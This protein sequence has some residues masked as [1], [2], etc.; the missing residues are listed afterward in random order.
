MEIRC[1]LLKYEL[2]TKCYLASFEALALIYCCK[3]FACTNGF[4]LYHSSDGLSPVVY[5]ARS[6]HFCRTSVH[7]GFVVDKVGCGE[8]YLKDVGLMPAN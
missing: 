6:P 4:R 2:N 5:S 1:I 7:V 3:G 8:V